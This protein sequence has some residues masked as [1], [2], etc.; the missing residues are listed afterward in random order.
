MTVESISRGGGLTLLW[1]NDAK[2][3]VRSFSENHIDVIIGK[4]EEERR[5]NGD[6]DTSMH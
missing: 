4:T 6:P 5:W 2:V 1:M 3:E